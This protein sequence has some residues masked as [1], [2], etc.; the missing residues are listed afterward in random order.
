MATRRLFEKGAAGQH[1]AVE[2]NNQL[3][4]LSR[5]QIYT[6]DGS[7]VS[8]LAKD[9]VEDEF[10]KRIGKPGRYG[11]AEEVDFSKI[12]V[13]KNPDRKEITTLYTA[14]LESPLVIPPRLE[15][16]A[17]AVDSQK[18]RGTGNDAFIVSNGKS[19]AESI[20]WWNHK[21]W[22]ETNSYAGEDFDTIAGTLAAPY[23]HSDNYP[24]Q[25]LE[26]DPTNDEFSSSN[27]GKISGFRGSTIIPQLQQ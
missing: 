21:G 4:V 8:L 18:Y 9:R 20:V 11:G 5:D 27:T 10:F 2:F 22:G 26:Y 19:G 24:T 6:T 23:A 13:V 7:R 25:W 16:L 17:S 1:C 12:Q 15:L 3:Y 14:Q